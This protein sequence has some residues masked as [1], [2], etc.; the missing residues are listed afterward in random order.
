MQRIA[1]VHCPQLPMDPDPG[2]PPG[3]PLLRNCNQHPYIQVTAR[4]LRHLHLRLTVLG[5]PHPTNLGP[6][7]PHLKGQ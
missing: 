3:T 6:E 2:L 5:C 7:R 1:R 4:T